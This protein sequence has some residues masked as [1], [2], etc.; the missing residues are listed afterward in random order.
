MPALFKAY[1]TRVSEISRE[2]SINPQGS[3]LCD[4]IFAGHIGLDSG[5]IWAAATSNAI[6]VHLLACMLARIFTGPEATSVWVELVDTRKQKIRED[7][8]EAMYSHKTSASLLAAEQDL[9]R[10]D[11]GNWDSSARAW[12]QSADQA[13]QRQHKQLM[14]ILDNASIPISNEPWLYESVMGA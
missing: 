9:S 12:L 10:S 3:S 6:G 1:G 7:H 2:P 8:S 5:S 13:K 14:L 11:L 4:G